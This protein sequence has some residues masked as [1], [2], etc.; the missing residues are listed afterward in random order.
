M[1]I[2]AIEDALLLNDFPLFAFFFILPVASLLLPAL[3]G[4]VHQVSYKRDSLG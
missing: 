2:L 4:H 3:A 1:N